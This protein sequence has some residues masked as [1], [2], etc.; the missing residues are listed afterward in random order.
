MPLAMQTRKLVKSASVVTGAAA[1]LLLL[2][3]LPMLGTALFQRDPSA[4]NPYDT[5]MK[6]SASSNSGLVDGL[7]G[8][9]EVVYDDTSLKTINRIR[10]CHNMKDNKIVHGANAD[11]CYRV[12]LKDLQSTEGSTFISTPIGSGLTVYAP[13]FSKT[14]GG[15]IQ[16]VFGRKL[17]L[18]GSNDYR[19]LDLK[20]VRTS[21]DHMMVTL[22]N[23]RYVDEMRLDVSVTIALGKGGV[24][25]ATFFSL[26]RVAQEINLGDLPKK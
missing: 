10:Y 3:S 26:G 21:T 19:V 8:R 1:A 2:N 14:D 5:V 17:R 6:F 24:N 13:N 12:E 22:A 9:I 11:N 7:E 25:S 16:F 23:G 18:I 20:F 15:T 4:A